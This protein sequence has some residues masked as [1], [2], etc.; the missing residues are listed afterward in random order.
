MPSVPRPAYGRPSPPIEQVSPSPQPTLARATEGYD[1]QFREHLAAAII[2]AIPEASRVSDQNTIAIR[3]TETCDALADVMG[4]MLTL[5]PAMSVPSKLRET[6]EA[7]AKKLRVDVARA[8][9][10]GIGDRL[11]AS[12]FGGNA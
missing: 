9:A 3:T 1:E 8:R 4:A 5:N 10:A 6:C 7:L 11:G 2:T 12:E